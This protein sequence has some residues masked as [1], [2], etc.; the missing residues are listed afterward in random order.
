MLCKYMPVYKRNSVL[1]T[2]NI[3]IV[4][5]TK[6][7]VD[8][9]LQAIRKYHKKVGIQVFLCG[10]YINH[11]ETTV[12]LDFILFSPTLRED[13]IDQIKKVAEFANWMMALGQDHHLWVDVVTHFAYD[14]VGNFYNSQ[15]LDTGKVEKVKRMTTVCSLIEDGKTTWERRDKTEIAPEIYILENTIPK[16]KQMRRHR[17]GC[18][19]DAHPQ[20][21]AIV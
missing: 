13:D 17:E 20:L 8:V 12:D 10:G 9:Y 4:P 21:V 14:D 11:P 1:E 19:Q 15:A 3:M 5:P 18:R 6:E 2:S 7:A 16:E